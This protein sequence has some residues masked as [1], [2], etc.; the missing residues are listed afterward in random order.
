LAVL[1]ESDWACDAE[2]TAALAVAELVLLVVISDSTLY[3]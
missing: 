2:E 3:R 1:A